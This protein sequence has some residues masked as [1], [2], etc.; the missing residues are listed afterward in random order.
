VVDIAG[1]HTLAATRRVLKK[2]GTFLVVGGPKGR[3]IRPLDRMVGALVMRRFVSQRMLGFIAEVTREDLAALKELAEAGKLRPV[4]DRTYPLP[5][6]ADAIRYVEEG[7]VAGKVVI[8][9]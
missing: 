4:I 5:Q 2:E 6:T 3:V 7:H 8:S 1:S 9:V